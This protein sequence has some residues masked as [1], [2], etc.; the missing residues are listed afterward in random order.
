MAVERLQ[1]DLEEEQTMAKINLTA[2]NGRPLTLVGT[3]T[4][5]VGTMV[6]GQAD[7]VTV[8]AI[9]IAANNPPALSIALQPQRYSLKGIRQNMVFSV[10]IP[11]IDMVKETNYCG[12]VSGAKA[13]KVKDCN[14]KVFFGKLEA[15]PLLEKCPVNHAC[16]VLHILNMGSHYFVIG[17]IVES[18]I[19]EDCLTDGKPDPK[20]VKPFFFS[21]GKYFPLGEALP[22]SIYAGDKNFK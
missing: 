3:P 12:T 18:Y 19:S 11:S 21:G 10:N 17:R 2:G 9:G 14:L 15:A 7:F 8:G 20:K 4:V 1:H 16:E 6:E 13:D 22:D 5:L